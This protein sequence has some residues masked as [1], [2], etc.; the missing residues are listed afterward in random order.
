MRLDMILKQFIL[1]TIDK[2]ITKKADIQTHTK[3]NV[4]FGN[5]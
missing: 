3:L 1:D 2:K 5:F 4:G